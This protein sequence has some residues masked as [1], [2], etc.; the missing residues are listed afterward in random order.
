MTATGSITRRLS[1]ATTGT[2]TLH[3]LGNATSVKLSH[4]LSPTTSLMGEAMVG[5]N[6]SFLRSLVLY[7]PVS[8]YLLKAGLQAGTMGVNLLYGIEHEFAKMTTIGSSVI[9]GPTQGVVL[10]LKLVR[11]SMDFN[12]RIK[13]SEFVGGVAVLYATCLP[14]VVYACIKV[15]AVAPIVRNEWLKEVRERRSKR[16]KEMEEK[17]KN[18]ESAIELMQETVERVLSIE[19]AKHGLLIM[20]AWYGKLFDHQ[21]DDSMYE[22]K[23]IDVR[24]PLQCLVAESKLILRETSKANIPG[25]YDP[26]IGEKKYLRVKYEFRGVAH[27]VTVENSEPLVIPRM[28]HRLVDQAEL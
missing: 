19:Q 20:E 16:A 4:Q 7:H 13:M 6:V 10:K 3:N 12:V 24:I 27:E 17:K 8:H 23:V 11:A 1:E 9:I 5:E 28:S 22:T 2:I 15:L 26:C 21:S 25:F 14:L 18:A